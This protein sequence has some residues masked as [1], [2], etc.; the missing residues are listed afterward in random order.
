M[1]MPLRGTWLVLAA[2]MLF[3][4]LFAGGARADSPPQITV[5]QSA[6]V[7]EAGEPFT[8]ELKALV[9]NGNTAPS[10]PQLNAPPSFTIDGPSISTQ[11][12]MNGFGARMTVRVGIGAT[13]SLVG[14][15][16]G[17][18]KIP[19]PSV[20][21]GG[22]RIAGDALRVEVV[23]STGRPRQRPSN[24][25]FLLPGGPG[26]FNFPWPFPTE[27]QAEEDDTKSPPELA[28]PTAPDPI[29]FVRAIVDKQNAVVGEQVTLSFYMYVR[30]DVYGRGTQVAAW[31][32]APLA[33]FVRVP[34]LKNPGTEQ[35]VRTTAGGHRYIA[36]LFDR[37]AIFPVKTGDLHTGSLR[38]TFS[39]A[40]L[41][42]HGDRE[43][44]DQ[45]IRVT[46]PPRNGRPPGYALGDVGQ[47]TLAA[48]VQPRRI[49]QGGAV[50][51]TLRI[52]GTGNLP[53]SLRLPERT[54]IEWLDPEKK[55][56]IE[57]QNGVVGGSRTFGYVVRVGESGTVDLGEVT[58]PYWDPGA[59]A[60]QVARATLGTIEVTPTS[61]LANGPDAGA[62]TP[63]QE[64]KAD[65]FV[66]LP[67]ARTTLSAYTAAP[68]RRL[69]GSA[70]W[71]LVAAPPLLVGV[72]SAG[73][74]AMRRARTRRAAAADSPAALAAKALRDAS[75]AEASGDAK[76][77]AA[78]LDR[79]VHLAVEA[80][81]G[82]KSRGVLL[83][84]LPSEM[85]QRSLPR[86]LGD[87]AA[88]I[89]SDCET[90]RFEPTPDTARTRDLVSRTR[91]L[92]ADLGRREAT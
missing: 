27:P 75:A 52:A 33:D 65:P 79:A 41:G 61:P 30:A 60:Y 92:V 5:R 40:R 12:I 24:N 29:A 58:L 32:E 10:D 17:K 69:D 25:P 63:F 28:L 72:F 42:R 7:V 51:V 47:M 45:V 84:D 37:V 21:W 35:P 4:L 91:K 83:A 66:G 2:T 57:P 53:Q 90:I 16:P 6:E 64:P 78:A 38:I 82:L 9:D 71:L 87:A 67:P 39:G 36:K 34:L 89:L 56:A 22:K 8:V 20:L 43:T 55:D 49:D 46:E 48:T 85:A 3:G 13:W 68:A 18:Y 74:N 80:A 15:T 62:P 31:H 14:R 70:L 23:P 77:I 11:T 19:A 86:E 54:G 26:G 44:A 59:K 1:S 81:C 76:A 73:S 88:A 50:S